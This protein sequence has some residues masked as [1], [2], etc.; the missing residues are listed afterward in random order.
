MNY[1]MKQKHWE[2]ETIKIKDSNE[3]IQNMGFGDPTTCF[4]EFIL[5]QYASNETN[6]LQYLI[7]HVMV[8]CIK[9]KNSVAHMF[10]A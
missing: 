1:L 6:I 2:E 10:Y 4:Y 3:F 7:M 5:D 9:L 8:L